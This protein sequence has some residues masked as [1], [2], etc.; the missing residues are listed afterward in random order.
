MNDQRLADL[1][2]KY[3]DSFVL[4]PSLDP[5]KVREWADGAVK[6]SISLIW[7]EEGRHRAKEQWNGESEAIGTLPGKSQVLKLL[8]LVIKTIRSVRLFEKHLGQNIQRLQDDIFIPDVVLLTMVEVGNPAYF[9]RIRK[10]SRQLAEPF[11]SML[12]LGIGIRETNIYKE[13]WENSDDTE[14]AILSTV[15]PHIQTLIRND[16]NSD[17]VM[18]RTSD[19]AEAF[20]R[21][22]DPRIVGLYFHEISSDD[23]VRKVVRQSA[24]DRLLQMAEKPGDDLTALSLEIASFFPDDPSYIELILNWMDRRIAGEANEIVSRNLLLGLSMAALELSSSEVGLFGAKNRAAMAVGRYFRRKDVDKS[25]ANL[26][27][28]LPNSDEFATNM[29]TTVILASE[30]KMRDFSVVWSDEEVLAILEEF[31]QRIAKKV[32][33]V[34]SLF[35]GS[36]SDTPGK[37]VR[38][39][40]RVEP[41]AA[42]RGRPMS[43]EPLGEFLVRHLSL[44]PNDFIRFF[45]EMPLFDQERSMQEY[46]P[47]LKLIDELFGSSGFRTLCTSFSSETWSAFPDPVRTCLADWRQKN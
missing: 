14:Q 7:T 22:S 34:A 45:N 32:G 26:L 17:F 4:V 16:S 25:T 11:G 18:R 12:P 9:Q 1:L 31:E 39:W 6:R 19:V 29:M 44:N 5:G 23:Y 42:L 41:F 20:N 30:R 24:R 8:P 43:I 36:F 28:Q 2:G 40:H 21:V 13:L 10:L 15:F 3:F 27:I 46:V 37:L 47:D 35:D 33:A 38:T